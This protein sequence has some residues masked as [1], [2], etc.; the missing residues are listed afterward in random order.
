MPNAPSRKQR[1]ISSPSV[2]KASNATHP[3]PIGHAACMECMSGYPG[4][5]GDACSRSTATACEVCAR[6]YHIGSSRYPGQCLIC[7]RQTVLL[8]VAMVV[9]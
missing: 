6:R 5:H 2:T 8:F 4:V 3:S 9:A 1:K 7:E